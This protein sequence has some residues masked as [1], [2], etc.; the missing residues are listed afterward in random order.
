MALEL[1]TWRQLAQ[2][3]FVPGV[4]SA[5]SVAMRIETG[6]TLALIK[7]RCPPDAGRHPPVR[8]VGGPTIAI[9]VC[10]GAAIT[11]ERLRERRWIIS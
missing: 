11:R 3:Q 9:R 6:I 8:V 10:D 5:A 7:R 4:V 1:P 2:R